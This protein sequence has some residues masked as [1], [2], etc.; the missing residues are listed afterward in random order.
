MFIVK[1]CP[2]SKQWLKHGQFPYDLFKNRSLIECQK[3]N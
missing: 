1:L 2:T 3:N